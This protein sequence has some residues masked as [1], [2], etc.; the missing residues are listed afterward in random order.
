MNTTITSTSTS[1]KNTLGAR[2]KAAVAV[3]V[4]LLTLSATMAPAAAAGP[5]VGA[6]VNANGDL[7]ITARES[8]NNIQIN[9]IGPGSYAIWVGDVNNP[10]YIKNVTG[11]TRHVIFTAK[12]HTGLEVSVGELSETAI[13]GDFRAVVPVPQPSD[14][15]DVLLEGVTVGG[16]V[17]GHG[18]VYIELSNTTVGDDVVATFKGGERGYLHLKNGTVVNDMV[19][20]RAGTTGA[21]QVDFADATT[22]RFRMV[23]GPGKDW[24]SIRDGHLGTAPQVLLSGGDDGAY[25][26]SG[27]WSGMM[28]FSGGAGEDL[29]VSRESQ[30]HGPI[31]ARMNAGDDYV[32]LEQPLSNNS[33]NSEFYGGAGVDWFVGDENAGNATIASF[34][35]TEAA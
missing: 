13:P 10:S 17:R 24:F 5:P 32:D 35:I 26:N 28:T 25:L 34:H 27:S 8:D 6:G 18:H 16:D 22:S 15:L 11:V 9:S 29:L 2:R 12:N 4:A 20:V 33:A 7:V 14:T 23:G 1:A 21:L 3:L 31:S 19:N 30:D